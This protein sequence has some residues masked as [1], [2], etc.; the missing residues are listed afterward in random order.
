MKTEVKH[1][2][3]TLPEIWK[4]SESIIFKMATNTKF[5]KPETFRGIFLHSTKMFC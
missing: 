1:Q 5:R 4:R 2:P 3:L